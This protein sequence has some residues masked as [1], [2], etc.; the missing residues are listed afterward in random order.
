MMASN[1]MFAGN[2]QLQEYMRNMLPTFLQQ[3][4]DDDLFF[5][6]NSDLPQT[7]SWSFDRMYW[8][9]SPTASNLNNSKVSRF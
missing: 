3:V 4:N 1:P 5:G 7:G 2:P 9:R 6:L 8:K